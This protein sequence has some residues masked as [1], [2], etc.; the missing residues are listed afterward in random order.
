MLERGLVVLKVLRQNLAFQV[1]RTNERRKTGREQRSEI[2]RGGRRAWKQ[3]ARMRGMHGVLGGMERPAGLMRASETERQSDRQQRKGTQQRKLET[4]KLDSSTRRTT[5]MKA[6]RH[7]GVAAAAVG[8]SG[9]EDAHEELVELHR[10][11]P[12]HEEKVHA[13]RIAT[14]S[15]CH[16]HAR[17]RTKTR[18]RTGLRS[19]RNS[20]SGASETAT[21][22]V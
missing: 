19:R 15:L 21:V 16:H 3:R 14:D 7:P 12:L 11:P 20:P 4:R 18:L 8:L 10:V 2:A 5:R 1:E 17:T 9:R 6:G 13:C 22:W